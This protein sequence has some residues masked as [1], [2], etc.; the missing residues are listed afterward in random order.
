MGLQML[1]FDSYF[2]N[3]LERKIFPEIGTEKSRI[4]DT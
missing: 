2:V 4:D 3:D 1:K